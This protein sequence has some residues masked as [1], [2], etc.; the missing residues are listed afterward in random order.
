MEPEEFPD[1]HQFPDLC[2]CST[3]TQPSDCLGERTPLWV[4][5]GLMGVVA[6]GRLRRRAAWRGRRLWPRAQPA[7]P[8]GI[9]SRGTASVLNSTTRSF[10]RE[11]ATMA[12][13]CWKKARYSSRI[14]W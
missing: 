10:G 3:S 7:A 8:G 11:S 4:L 12:R 6:R 14:R 9:G 13:I 5:L 1:G 2:T